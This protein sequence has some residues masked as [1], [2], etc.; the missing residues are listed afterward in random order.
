MSLI[1]LIFSYYFLSVHFHFR[2]PFPGSC[3]S[4]LQGF[5]PSDACIMLENDPAL[6]LQIILQTNLLWKSLHDELSGQLFFSSIFGNSSGVFSPSTGALHAY[7]LQRMFATAL[8][9]SGNDC[10][11]AVQP[12]SSRSWAF[13]NLSNAARSSWC[14]N[15]PSWISPKT[16]NANHSVWPQS[17]P[18]QKTIQGRQHSQL[19]LSDLAKRAGVTSVITRSTTWARTWWFCV[20]RLWTVFPSPMRA[21]LY[22]QRCHLLEVLII[23]CATSAPEHLM[24]MTLWNCIAF[25]GQVN[26]GLSFWICS[27]TKNWVVQCGWFGW[28]GPIAHR[29]FDKTGSRKERH[30]GVCNLFGFALKIPCALGHCFSS[31]APSWV[32]L[33]LGTPW[34]TRSAP[35]KPGA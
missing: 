21:F 15:Y 10:E 3:R 8:R 19:L 24:W 11:T 1:S 33:P 25:R 20:M 30:N 28:F 9:K 17:E 34:T 13:V 16:R 22:G 32:K 6:L 18:F 35:P 14:W 23:I 26:T 29:K 31:D 5:P 7:L 27:M 4:P 2:V 12:C